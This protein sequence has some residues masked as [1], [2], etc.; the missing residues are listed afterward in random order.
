MTI[1]AEEKAVNRPKGDESAARH[2]PRASVQLKRNI[3]KCK[4][5][6]YGSTGF[7]VLSKK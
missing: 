2:M 5:R 4:I 6:C 1:K 3:N 7:F